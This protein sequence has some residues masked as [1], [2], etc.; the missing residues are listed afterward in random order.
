MKS[1][2]EKNLFF[3]HLIAKT[4]KNKRILSKFTKT[5]RKLAVIC[6]LFMLFFKVFKQPDYI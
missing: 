4:S 5:H 6:F 1:L 2:L 3:E